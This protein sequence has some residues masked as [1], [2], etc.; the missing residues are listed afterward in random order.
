MSHDDDGETTQID[1]V[2]RPVDHLITEMLTARWLT[3]RQQK[4]WRPATDVY[5]TNESVIVKVEVAG[6]SERDFTISLSNRNL[7]IT[8]IRNDPEAKLAYQQLE[9]PYGRFRTQVFLSYAVDQDRI[10]ASYKDGFLTIV[11]PK[12][13]PRSIRIQQTNAHKEQDK[14]AE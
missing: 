8:G 11:L 10:T 4:T 6:M 2:F 9:I 12:S 14:S 1:Q 3:V 7:V 5:E 13:Q